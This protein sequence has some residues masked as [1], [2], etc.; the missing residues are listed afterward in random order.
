MLGSVS[1]SFHLYPCWEPGAGSCHVKTVIQHSTPWIFL[2]CQ[3]CASLC[4]QGAHGLERQGCN[5]AIILQCYYIH[6][7]IIYTVVGGKLG[8]CSMVVRDGNIRWLLGGGDI[9][10]KI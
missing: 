1:D 5:W 7:V 3:L 9:K 10:A 4:S 2:V 8:G 6:S